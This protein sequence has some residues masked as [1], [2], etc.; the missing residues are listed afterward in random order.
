MSK[1]TRN[2]CLVLAGKCWAEKYWAELYRGASL[3]IKRTSLGPYLRPM[4]RVL[5]GS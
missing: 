4:P 5:G 1:C 2:P 3:K